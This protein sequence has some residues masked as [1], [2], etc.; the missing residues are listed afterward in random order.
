MLAVG[1]AIALCAS[2]LV[3]RAFRASS[4]PS[5]GGLSVSVGY[6]EDKEI[7]TPNPMEFPTPWAGSPNT[8]FLGGTVPGQTACGSLPKCYDAGAIRL[9]N[10]TSA[11]ITVDR[12]DV[13]IHSSITGGKLFPNL[14]GSFTVAPGQSA[15]LTENPPAN[16]PSYDNFDTSGYP[17]NNCTPITV[18]PT[19]TITIKGVATTL[20]DSTHV[21]D[22]GGIDTGYCKPAHNESI[23]WRAIGAAG[24]T[25]ASL[26]LGPPTQTAF[27]GASV[28]ETA[29]LL[30]GAGAGLPNT[31]VNFV[32]KSGPDAGRSGIAVTDAN[33][34]ATFTYASTSEGEDLVVAS[35]ATVGTITSN[36]TR[37]M[38]TDASTAGW[39]A[40][41]I[42]SATPP[43]SETVDSSG[44]WTVTGGGSGVDGTSDQVHFL[45]KPLA[46]AGG[47]SAQ[48]GAQTATGGAAKTG[49]MMRASAQSNSQYYA[50]FVTAAGH[51]V[52]QSRATA[53][54]A[55][56]TLVD[57]VRTQPAFVWIFTNG[58]Q[59]TSYSSVDGYEWT[60]IAGSTTTL[61]LGAAPLAGLA[62]T[63][64]DS[65]LLNTATVS[66][67]AVAA[68]P[69]AP[70][71]PQVC[72]AP[73]SCADI[74]SPSPP[75]GQSYDPGTGTWTVNAG[76]ADISGTADQFRFV[77]QPLAGD[78]SISVRVV[79][80]TNT[81]SSAKAGVMLRASSDPGSPNY[82]VLVSPGAG[83]KVQ[84]RTTL[85]GTTTKL[86]NPTGTVPVYLKATRVGNAFS[87]YTSAD[88]VT[89]Q[90]ISGS[91]TTIAT[92]PSVVFQGLAVTSHKN[93]TSGT[94]TFDQTNAPPT[95]A[96]T[97]TT[98]TTGTT[99]SGSSSTTTTS[100]IDTS[101]CPVPWSCAD[102]G[103]PLPAGSQSYDAFTGIWTVSAGGA[104]ISGALD[105]FRFVSEPVSGDASITA[106][107]ATQSNSSSNAKA[108]VM[109]RAG[110]DPGAPNYAV[111]VSPGVGIKVQLR[112]AL[113]G[114]TT[115]LANPAGVAPVWLR[116]TRS[117]ATFSAFTSPDGVSWTLIPGSQATVTMPVTLLG[118]LAVTS[119]STGVLGTA[120]FD[121]VAIG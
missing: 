101:S 66:A 16:N 6:A 51:L 8:L 11:P 1:I 19:V 42:G 60:P 30:D 48:L 86:A 116:I 14:W 17:S 112:T 54:T 73:W 3:V 12:V 70:P 55:P 29:T 121:G 63:S 47:V 84:V 97:S 52:V 118:G 94:V 85:G 9:D 93:G 61:G 28:S 90:P 56:V 39:N 53:G 46:G 38:W 10:P 32:V 58:S 68:T 79:S 15:I 81:S 96:P 2:L 77:S 89:W 110:T 109:L 92:M 21:L 114:T 105:Q 18:P 27:A 49:V 87:A 111:L 113:G 95:T 74:G 100:V 34:H 76:G 120:T 20:S 108:G 36:T 5:A 65:A 78:G 24:S 4:V 103:N 72:P 31:T 44:V 80:Q 106:H 62:V 26:S 40:T 43:G 41:D 64:G 22:T 91:A 117:G 35:V 50:A 104:D 75:G 71:S 82:A 115:K 107:V 37:V 99:S 33:G 67:V 7:N 23:Q 57:N 102:I 119:H 88:G 13:D 45:S 25:T 59:V 69:P 98:T 83:I